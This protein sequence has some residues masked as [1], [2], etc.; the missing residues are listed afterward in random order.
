[1]KLGFTRTFGVVVVRAYKV[2]LS[3]WLSP[4]CRFTPTC[5]EYAG[6]AI[7]EYG[8]LRGAARAACRLLRCHPLHGGGFDPLK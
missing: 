3:P 2:V 6:E 5:S 8:L 4:A 1:M 7:E